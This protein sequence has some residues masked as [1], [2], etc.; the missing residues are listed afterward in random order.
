MR[1]GSVCIIVVFSIFVLTLPSAAQDKVVVVVPIIDNE[2]TGDAQPEDVLEG[3]TFSSSSGTGLTGTMPDIGK[4]D[5]N[6]GT[7]D[8]TISEGYH[9]GSG[10]VAGDTDL[11]AGNIKGGVNIFGVTGELQGGCTCAG[12]L[13][14]TRWCDNGDGTVTDLSTCLVWLQ[15]ANCN[16]TLNWDATIIWSSTLSGR[17]CDMSDGSTEGDWRL[18]TKNELYA[19]AHGAEAVRS[20]T[21][22]AFSGVQSDYYWSSTTYAGAQNDEAWV[23]LMSNGFISYSGKANTCYVW[24]VRGD[25]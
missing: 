6:P 15:D 4:Q 1:R 13:N 21:P 14:G 5:I 2:A 9:D 10:I 19:I 23:V 22:R 7:Q 8:Q 25:Y 24:P 20:G 11:V 18:P 12:T 3:I 16:G 17:A